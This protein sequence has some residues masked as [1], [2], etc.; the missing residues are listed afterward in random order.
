MFG[1]DGFSHTR[2]VA[3]TVKPLP[4]P[5][6]R[7]HIVGQPC[8]L[9]NATSAP[10]MDYARMFDRQLLVSGY[11]HHGP[12]ARLAVIRWAICNAISFVMND[13]PD[14]EEHSNSTT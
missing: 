7:S 3:A 4:Q 11:D 13:W 9:T 1:S 12:A 6:K 2:A 8:S 5:T 10:H 14:F